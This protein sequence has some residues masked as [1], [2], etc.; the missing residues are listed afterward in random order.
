MAS[1]HEPH[2]STCDSTAS[3]LVLLKAT[4]T[5]MYT[6]RVFQLQLRQQYRA[7]CSGIAA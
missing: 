4:Y 6:G 2:A 1:L 3:R 5:I 7:G